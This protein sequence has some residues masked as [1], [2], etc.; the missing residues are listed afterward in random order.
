M[1]KRGRKIFGVHCHISFLR[2]HIFSELHVR[3]N[4]LMCLTSVGSD[5]AVN[6]K[7]FSAA[8]FHISS[9][10]NANTRNNTA[11][12]KQP[13]IF[14]FWEKYHDFFHIIRTCLFMIY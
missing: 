9:L 6:A 13:N 5:V 7:D 1:K 14:W 4:L 12:S 11:A 8:F 10:K 3:I 2:S